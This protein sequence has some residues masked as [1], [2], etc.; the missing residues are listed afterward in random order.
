MDAASGAA[1]VWWWLGVVALFVVVVPLV[2]LLAQR[3]LRRILEIRRYAD[4]ILEHGLGVT[5][6]LEPVPALGRTRELV[7]S[8]GEKL[9][10]YVQTVGR[11]L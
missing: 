9:E 2:L 4:D 6:N 11:M 5:A 7:R 10:S 1:A 8:A 3:L